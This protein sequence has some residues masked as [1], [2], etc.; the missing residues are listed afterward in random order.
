M[1]SALLL[2]LNMLINPTQETN[3]YIIIMHAILHLHVLL[4]GIME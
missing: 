4:S 1:A 3:M 2:P